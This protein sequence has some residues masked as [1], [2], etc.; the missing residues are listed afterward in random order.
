M[1]VGFRAPLSGALFGYFDQV[2][3]DAVVSFAVDTELL[4]PLPTLERK[5]A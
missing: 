5:M 4:N 1:F 2:A 3:H